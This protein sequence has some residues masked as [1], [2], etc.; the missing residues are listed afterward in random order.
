MGKT[1]KS[2]PQIRGMIE[3]TKTIES[4]NASSFSKNIKSMMLPES[5][6]AYRLPDDN[7]AA[8][9]LFEG[10]EI[11]TLET[12]PAFDFAGVGNRS[13]VYSEGISIINPTIYNGI[14]LSKSTTT[15]ISQ[16]Q[17]FQ[18]IDFV[19]SGAKDTLVTFTGANVA[20]IPRELT[21]GVQAFE[22]PCILGD[23]IVFNTNV[24]LG[25]KT[26]TST[27]TL[28]DDTTIFIGNSTFVLTGAC[29][30]VR[31]ALLANTPFDNS[32]FATFYNNT[33]AMTLPAG[34]TTF[35]AKSFDAL[36]S[37]SETF[38][39]R[40][41][42]LSVLTTYQGSDLN[43]GG[44]IS[45]ARLPM[46]A[47][48]SDAALGDVYDYLASLP[49]YA[50]DYA[51][52]E[53]A[54][55]WWLPDSISEYDFKPYRET[56]LYD[57]SSLVTAVSRKIADDGETI[58]IR[59]AAHFET[60][61]RSQQYHTEVTNYN[62]MLPEMIALAKTLPAVTCNPEHVG[63]FTRMWRKFKDAVSNPSNWIK[64]AEVGLPYLASIIA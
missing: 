7:V 8:S 57:C 37:M 63:F 10:L 38:K 14:Y 29:Q 23:N 13:A 42:A 41:T 15:A 11:F 44:Q 64:A 49:A 27:G 46:G 1:L 36:V 53:G 22:Y 26:Y 45:A 33:R 40:C 54:Y 3:P 19:Q 4:I 34:G 39:A 2:A 55:T 52:K 21:P 43:N 47:G 56:T 20:L 59:I 48:I 58:R 32:T 25:M 51:L 28:V 16:Y 9:A 50:G 35:Q 62:P 61:T 5:E 30:F 6:Q 24:T 12:T 17:T 18:S 31:I 60:L